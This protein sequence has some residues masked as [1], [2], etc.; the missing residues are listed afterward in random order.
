MKIHKMSAVKTRAGCGV[1]ANPFNPIKLEL[2]AILLMGVLLWLVLPS[3]KIGARELLVLGSY[4]LAAMLWIIAR[5][6]Y[7]QRRLPENNT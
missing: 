2:T 3:L 7:V 4:G 1:A 6:R 5:V